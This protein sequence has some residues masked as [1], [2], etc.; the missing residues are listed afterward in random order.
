M[1]HIESFAAPNPRQS[2]KD[3][4]R[5]IGGSGKNFQDLQLSIRKIDAVSKCAAGIDGYAQIV[6]LS[7]RSVTAPA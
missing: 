1:P 6:P 3:R 4:K 7:Y 2:L 5:R